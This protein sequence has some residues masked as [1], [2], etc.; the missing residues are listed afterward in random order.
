MI[1]ARIKVTQTPRSLQQICPKS[2]GGY[3]LLQCSKV[4]GSVGYTGRD[5]DRLGGAAL[6]P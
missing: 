1:T 4:V 6:D 2:S 5:G 3:P